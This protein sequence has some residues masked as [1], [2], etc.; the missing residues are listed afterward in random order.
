ML[1]EDAP[2]AVPCPFDR[3]VRGDKI[4]FPDVRDVLPL[5]DE[6]GEEFDGEKE[7]EN[8]CR[9]EEKPPGR[10][11]SPETWPVVR[12][13]R[14]ALASLDVEEVRARDLAESAV[15]VLS[16]TFPVDILT[17]SSRLRL[18]IQTRKGPD[19]ADEQECQKYFD[20]KAE[21]GGR[22]PVLSTPM[23]IIEGEGDS[24]GPFSM[25]PSPLGTQSVSKKTNP[26][27]SPLSVHNS[28]F[29]SVKNGLYELFCKSADAE[30]DEQEG[31]PASPGLNPWKT[32]EEDAAGE[33]EDG[34]SFAGIS[35]ITG[36]SPICLGDRGAVEEIEDDAITPPHMARVLFGGEG[37]PE[38]PPP[39]AHRRAVKTRSRIGGD[40]ETEVTAEDLSGLRLRLA[41]LDVEED[42]HED[43]HEE[44]QDQSAPV[45][46]PLTPPVVE[47]VPSFLPQLAQRRAGGSDADVSDA[48]DD[49]FRSMSAS[50]GAGA[51]SSMDSPLVLGPRGIPLMGHTSSGKVRE[52]RRGSSE[53]TSRRRSKTKARQ[54]HWGLLTA[55][56]RASSDESSGH[57]LG[58]SAEHVELAPPSSVLSR[59]YRGDR[60]GMDSAKKI[61]F[62]DDSAE[63]VR[64]VELPKVNKDSPLLKLIEKY[65]DPAKEQETEQDP[66]AFAKELKSLLATM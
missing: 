29:E 45:T 9:T 52:R 25:E 8:P 39:R 3:D 31:V 5:E 2:D 22:D 27:C 62:L 14:L 44:V 24:P 7:N 18:E 65:K 30:D 54:P 38:A 12:G 35:P 46:P 6:L 26:P 61:T 23:S 11:A 48:G 50:D 56:P 16:N 41:E 42:V 59:K 17:P 34:V 51:S 13:R 63:R 40:D 66:L 4:N 36:P 58:D 37:M 53:V 64:K 33:D 49:T 19:E 28:S 55:T 20:D 60:V 10:F 15:E 57:L 32:D 21:S 43:V 1:T 47:A